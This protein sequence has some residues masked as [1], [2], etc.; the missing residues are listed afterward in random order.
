[1]D[2]FPIFLRS[3]NRILTY[4]GFG[5]LLSGTAGAVTILPSHQIQAPSSS[6][7][8]AEMAYTTT[9]TNARG[10]QVV[11]GRSHLLNQHGPVANPYHPV[12]QSANI[13][14]FQPLL[15]PG[16]LSPNQGIPKNA[17]LTPQQQLLAKELTR[18]LTPLKNLSPEDILKETFPNTAKK[19]SQP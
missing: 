16:N 9:M 18:R 14:K 11:V 1:M 10:Q 17:P 3:G 15:V 6:V 12:P 5:F 2:C 8:R 13:H 7:P 19:T 4:I